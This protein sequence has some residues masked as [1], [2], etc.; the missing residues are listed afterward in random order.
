MDATT[1]GFLG[2]TVACAQCHNHKFDPIPQK[3]Y[4]SL[5]GV[6]LQFGAEQGAARPK[7]VVEKWDAREEGSRQA[8]DEAR[9]N[10]SPRR[11]IS[12]AAILASQTVALPCWPRGN[13]RRRTI[14]IAETL[15][16]WTKYLA[17]PEAGP[18]A[19]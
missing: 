13:W 3:D 12:W 8:G 10:S 1:R 14:W 15:E 17:N 18:S 2:L 4:Y 7:D 11:P 9:R 5:Q 16:R 19:I 6:F